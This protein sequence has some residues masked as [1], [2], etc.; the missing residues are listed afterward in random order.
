MTRVQIDLADE[1]VKQIEALVAE[2]GLP[3]KKDFFTNAVTLL[4]WAMREVRAGRIIAS[5]DEQ[6]NRYKEIVLP[7][8]ENV[9]AL[10]AAASAGNGSK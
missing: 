9:A 5:V 3:T 8:F 4:A 6:N 7:A 2:A 10:A 1:K